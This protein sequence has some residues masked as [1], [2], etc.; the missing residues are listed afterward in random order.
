MVESN[1][2]PQ[3]PESDE[4]DSLIYDKSLEWWD[5]YKA[6][7][8]IQCTKCKKV[9]I[10]L[11]NE[12]Q[13]VYN[14]SAFNTLYV[15]VQKNSV[16]L[17]I[18]L[19]LQLYSKEEDVVNLLYYTLPLSVKSSDPMKVLDMRLRDQLRKQ[20][21][22]FQETSVD[23]SEFLKN[24]RIVYL[25]RKQVKGN[26]EVGKV[27][28]FMTNSSLASWNPR[29]CPSFL[30]RNRF[31]FSL[32]SSLPPKRIVFPCFSMWRV[33]SFCNSMEACPTIRTSAIR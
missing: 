8:S 3:L 22:A 1:Y 18:T 4:T 17:K 30:P 19:I 6:C 29:W 32:I 28:L 21:D 14:Y 20:T 13:C 5:H 15:P 12:A 7:N 9:F 2:I 10:W 27:R 11:S 33:C 16:T 23:F 31:L 24:S 26:F 25:L